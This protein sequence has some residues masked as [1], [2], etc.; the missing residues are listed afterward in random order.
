MGNENSAI[1]PEAPAEVH[2]DRIDQNGENNTADN[3]VVCTKPPASTTEQGVDPLQDIPGRN[4]EEKEEK[5]TR[6]EDE[7]LEF[8]HDF[9]PST[10][11]SLELH[12]GTSLGFQPLEPLV[13]PVAEFQSPSEETPTPLAPAETLPHWVQQ[14]PLHHWVRQRPLPC[15][16]Q[17]R[18]LPCWVQQRPLP[19]WVRQRPLPYWVLQRPLPYW[20]RQRP[21]PYWI[22][23]RPLP[24]CVRQRPLPC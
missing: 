24:H 16:V 2:A 17:Q 11:L 18:P 9:L 20:I 5:R 21:L 1:E 23:Q 19:Y 3:I 14:R 22:R 6:D 12:W 7:D 15:W 8:P 10:D 4:T 13:S